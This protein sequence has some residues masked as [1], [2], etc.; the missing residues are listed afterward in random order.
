MF[1]L[2]FVFLFPALLGFFWEFFVLRGE[3]K[4]DVSFFLLSWIG[5][6]YILWE[7]VLL[8]LFLTEWWVRGEVLTALLNPINFVLYTY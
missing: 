7:G 5:A 8:V 4:G 2:L 3:R 1:F 6:M